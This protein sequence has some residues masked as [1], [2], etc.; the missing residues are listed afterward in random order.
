MILAK[1]HLHI[2]QTGHRCCID[3]D[4]IVFFLGKMDSIKGTLR[5]YLGLKIPTPPCVGTIPN[6]LTFTDRPCFLQKGK[7]ESFPMIAILTKCHLNIHKIFSLYGKILSL[8]GK[9]LSPHWP[10]LCQMWRI[11][12][13]IEFN[14]GLLDMKGFEGRGVFPRIAILN[15]YYLDIWNIFQIWI[16]QI[17]KISLNIIY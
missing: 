17:L 13:C 4:K 15:K 6:N 2:D 1:H 14:L 16:R 5:Y 10:N 8:Y 12:W 11:S 9:I 7:C 3:F